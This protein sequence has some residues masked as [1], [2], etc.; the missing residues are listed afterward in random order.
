MVTPGTYSV[1]LEKRVNGVHT[2]LQ[3]PTNF[4]VVPLFDGTLPRKSNALDFLGNVPSN[5]GTTSKFVGP[6]KV[7]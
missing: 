5:N 2:T 7:V 4:E 1:T 3:G 6:C